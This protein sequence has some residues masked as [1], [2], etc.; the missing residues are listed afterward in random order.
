[1][2]LCSIC[3]MHKVM[4]PPFAFRDS[5]AMSPLRCPTGTLQPGRTSVT[6]AQTSC[7]EQQDKM[8]QRWLV[9]TRDSLPGRLCATGDV[10][11]NS[12]GCFHFVL[13]FLYIS[14]SVEPGVM[15]TCFWRQFSYGRQEFKR[16]T[17]EIK[18]WMYGTSIF[19]LSVLGHHFETRSPISQLGAV[20]A[21]G[22][23][24]ASINPTLGDATLL[25]TQGQRRSSCSV[26]TEIN[27][28]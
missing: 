19:E 16:S 11:C 27:L 21:L 17:S 28:W 25:G 9:G 12:S 2:P 23:H 1:M 8:T 26:F 20:L 18:K 6:C 15:F 5:L 7:L 14:L 3:H 24:L 22:C 10:Q 13:V 4:P